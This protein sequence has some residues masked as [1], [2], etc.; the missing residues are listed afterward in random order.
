MCSYI[1]KQIGGDGVSG[2][3]LS[4]VFFEGASL[5][6]LED[7]DTGKGVHLGIYKGNKEGTRKSTG[8]EVLGTTIGAV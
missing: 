1:Q 3:V 7:P 8:V 5:E 6:H 2:L 4:R